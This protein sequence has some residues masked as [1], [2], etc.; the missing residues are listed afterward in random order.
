MSIAQ[1][2]G[3]TLPMLL[4]FFG[5]LVFSLATAILALLADY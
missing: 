5:V 2:L 4:V 3:L 1:S